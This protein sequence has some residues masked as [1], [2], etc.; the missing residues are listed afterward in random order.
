L[1]WV[2]DVDLDDSLGQEV[3]A[4]RLSS[5]LNQN[6]LRLAKRSCELLDYVVEVLE[7]RKL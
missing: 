3:D 5:P 1:A 6:I 2:I 4:V 7:V